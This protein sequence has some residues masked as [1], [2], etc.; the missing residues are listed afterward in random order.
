MQETNVSIPQFYRIRNHFVGCWIAH[1][2]NICSRSLGR[3]DG[4]ITFIEQYQT[5][6][7][8]SSRKLLAESKIKT[9]T[10]T[11]SRCWSIVRCRLRVTTNANS[12]QGES[13]LYIFE[14]NEAV[15]KMSRSPTMRHVSRTHRVAL[16][17]LFDRINVDPKIQI[18]YVDTKN[19]SQTCKPKGISHVMSGIIC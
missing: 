3:G 15:I 12:S 11:E 16:G 13:Q 2:W 4:R 18:K 14:D 19:H 8:S 9:Q 17:G 6:I 10:R 7:Q 5:T 1:G